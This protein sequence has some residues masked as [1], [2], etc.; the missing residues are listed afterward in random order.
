MGQ[1]EI[2][3]AHHARKGGKEGRRNYRTA[4]ER[5]RQEVHLKSDHATHRISSVFA[6]ILAPVVILLA[7][8]GLTEHW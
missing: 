5:A 4:A 1:L 7:L 3:N 6:A 8:P 2:V